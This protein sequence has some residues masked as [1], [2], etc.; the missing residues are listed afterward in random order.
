MSSRLARLRTAHRGAR[1]P[2]GARIP[3]GGL[4]G[5]PRQLHDGD[6]GLRAAGAHAAL[7]VRGA[8]HLP[9]H[10]APHGQLAPVRGGV[11]G[12]PGPR[13]PRREQRAR[14]EHPGH[15]ARARARGLLAQQP[16][17]PPLP[18]AGERAHRRARRQSRPR[19]P[20]GHRDPRRAARRDRARR[21]ARSRAAH[22]HRPVAA[23]RALP[24]VRRGAEGRSPTTASASAS[25]LSIRSPP[26]RRGDEEARAGAAASG[27][28][29]AVVRRQLRA[30][31][32]ELGA[33]HLPRRARGVLLLLSR[34]SPRRS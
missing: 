1:Q 28:R 8:L 5:G 9:A 34:C 2:L 25:R 27:A 21:R 13:L 33:R 10:P 22:R 16:A 31:D 20:A 26:A 7:V 3:S 18:G 24:G 6:R 23:A 30:R 15:R 14:R 12:Q 19:D 17:V 11:P 29:P 32:G 4:R